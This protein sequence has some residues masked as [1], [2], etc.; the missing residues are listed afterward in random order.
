MDGWITLLPIVLQGVI[1]HELDGPSDP[2][3]HYGSA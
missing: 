1:K 3:H 2:I